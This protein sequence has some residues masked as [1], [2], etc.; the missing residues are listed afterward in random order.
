MERNGIAF[1]CR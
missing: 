1:P